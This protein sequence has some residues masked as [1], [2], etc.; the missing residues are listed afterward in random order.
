MDGWTAALPAAVTLWLW[1]RSV[2][3]FMGC[4]LSHHHVP[5][6]TAV[7][8]LSATVLGSA[9]CRCSPSLSLGAGG[10]FYFPSSAFPSELPHGLCLL[11]TIT[12]SPSPMTASSLSLGVRF[13]SL[14][15]PSSKKV[16]VCHKNTSSRQLA[17]GSHLLAPRSRESD[18]LAC[19]HPRGG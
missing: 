17:A 2:V 16:F 9:E 11:L 15:H 8:K 13:T 1:T 14:F 5:L 18:V 10:Y 4:F 12:F 19:R 6:Q 7:A 3:A